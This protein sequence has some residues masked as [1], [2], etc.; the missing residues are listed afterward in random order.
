[1][2]VSTTPLRW[3]AI[4]N[5]PKAV[6]EERASRMNVTRL[7]YRKVNGASEVLEKNYKNRKDLSAALEEVDDASEFK[8][9]VVEDLSRDVIETLGYKFDIEPAFFRSHIVDYAWYNVRDR[10]IDPPS[11]EGDAKRQPWVQLRYVTA[12]YFKS[13]DEFREGCMKTDNFNVFRR[14]Y[15]DFS[16]KAQL[17]DK[18]AIVGITRTR[19]SLWMKAADNKNKGVIGE[20]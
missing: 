4:F 13:V 2:E 18:N 9:F 1:M 7:N 12:R 20:C 19:A 5:G 6:R 8:L 11:L 10:W 17:D 3:P 15:D 14:L 16:N